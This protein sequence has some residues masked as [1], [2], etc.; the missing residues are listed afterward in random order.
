[1]IALILL[2]TGH[3]W[4]QEAVQSTP[5]TTT[6][7]P[8][9]KIV[10]FTGEVGM[11]GELYNISGIP[12]RRPS[13]TGR[14]YLR[15]TLTA[16][17]SISTSI[18]LMLSNEGSS[19]RQDINQFDFNPRWKWGEAHA[20]DFFQDLSPLTLSG[21]KV[22]GGALLLAPGKWR[23]SLISGRTSRSVDASNG[24][25]SYERS[26]T[27]ARVG[28]GRIDGTSFDFI[29]VDARD[30]LSS[31]AVT[32]ADTTTTDTLQSDFEQNPLSVTPQ[33]NIVASTVFNLVLMNRKVH[34]RNEVSGCGITR[35]RRSAELD[36]S[37]VP[38]FLTDLFTP[39]KSSSA[40]FAYTTDLRA[41][42]KR[43]TL[44]GGFHYTGPGYVSLGLASLISDKQEITSGASLR[45]RKGVVRLDGAF[46]HDNLIH[47][48]SYTTNR[49]RFS[50]LLSYRLRSNWNATIAAIYT[51]MSNDA[52]SDTTRLDYGSWIL[53]TGHNYMFNRRQ[54]FRS[55]S[56]DLLY[57]HAADGNPLRKSS[58]T[59]SESGTL[60]TNYGI[61]SSLEIAPSIGLISSQV[62][63][64][65]R[66]LT[67]NYML[68]ARHTA[69]REKLSS[70]ATLAVIVGD[71][72]TTL[73]PQLRSAYLF[74]HDLTLTVEAEATSLKGGP[75]SGRFDE[76]AGRLILSR[77]F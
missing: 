43:L 30:R 77:R 60:S 57:Q 55:I 2:G 1:M 21:I 61:S 36:N 75:E 18:N 32:P 37:D 29:V 54:G 9:N 42:I 72:T 59:E 19:A 74:D 7:S 51:G 69:F 24:N 67:Q 71:V 28:F 34:W 5:P 3:S 45:L 65:G 15:S 22:R 70:S 49:L 47:Q 64:A 58:A 20:G 35:D 13:S 53:R 52:P 50:S 25:R 40:D 27:G 26:L 56:L 62:G 39:R 68:T 6:A 31:L 63:E 16:W 66:I 12:A 33:E 76:V 41:E 23:L 17:N 4:S 46:Q 8:T 10:D 44:T 73:R 48:K 14:V 38:S 11:F